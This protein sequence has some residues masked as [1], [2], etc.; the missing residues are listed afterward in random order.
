MMTG[1]DGND[2][3]LS[4]SVVICNT[5]NELCLCFFLMISFHESSPMPYFMIV[6]L[7]N[8]KEN[9]EDM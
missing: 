3:K 5:D 9:Q 6:F 1:Q 7:Y 4:L 2:D 8:L